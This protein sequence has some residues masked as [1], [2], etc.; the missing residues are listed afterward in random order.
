MALQ[1][2]GIEPAHT[3]KDNET[4]HW[5]ERERACLKD[6]CKERGVEIEVLGVDRDDYSIPEYKKAMRSKEAAE[7]EIEILMSEK[8]EAESFIASVGEQVGEYKEEIAEQK[9]ALD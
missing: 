9:T 6:L 7:A 3:K 2:Q 1:E 8:I 4:M 5:Q